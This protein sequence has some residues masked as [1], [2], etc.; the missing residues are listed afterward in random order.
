MSRHLK[1]RELH[2]APMSVSPDKKKKAG[3]AQVLDPNQ[4]EKYFCIKSWI[5]LDPVE[6][7]KEF[8]TAYQSYVQNVQRQTIQLTENV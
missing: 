6:V 8:K 5:S 3:A 7:I 1:W 4:K 2:D